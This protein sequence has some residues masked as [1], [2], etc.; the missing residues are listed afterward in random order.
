[1]NAVIYDKTTGKIMRSVDAPY[2]QIA[3]Q[4]APGQSYVLKAGDDSTDYVDVTTGYLLKRADYTLD[5]LPLP[6]V[7]TIEGVEYPCS[8]QPVFEFD[9]P[10]RYTVRVNAGAQYLEK[11]FYVDQ[12]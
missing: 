9:A 6:C 2:D 11:V 3:I 8:E 5:A 12:A 10:G 1:M 7:V 4:C